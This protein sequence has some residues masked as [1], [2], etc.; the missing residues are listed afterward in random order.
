MRLGL[1]RQR[2]DESAGI[3]DGHT[4]G[5]ADTGADSDPD[6][7]DASPS[8]TMRRGD[9]DPSFGADGTSRASAPGRR[10]GVVDGALL[11]DGRIVLLLSVDAPEGVDANLIALARHRS[12]GSL[13]ESF[14]RGGFVEHVLC[15]ERSEACRDLQPRAL[16]ALPDGRLLIAA[17]DREN[18]K[19]GRLLV[20][21]TAGNLDATF[22]E[23]G[24]VTLPALVE[25]LALKADGGVVGVG[26]SADGFALLHLTADLMLD[27]EF[28]RDG[29]RL[30]DVAGRTALQVFQHVAVQADGN[31]VAAGLLSLPDPVPALAR[32]TPEGDPDVAF[33]RSGWLI[34]E[35]TPDLFGG[36]SPAAGPIALDGSGGLLVELPESVA[37]RRVRRLDGEGS[38][39]PSWAGP[40]GW[41]HSLFVAAD[42]S[43]VAA[44]ARVVIDFG[45]VIPINGELRR[46][47][48][49]GAADPEF[50]E[51]GVAPVPLVDGRPVFVGAAL[52]QPD[53]KII[54]A[55]SAPD[56]GWVL[57]ASSTERR[58]PR[59]QREPAG[60]RHATVGAGGDARARRRSPA[61]PGGRSFARRLAENYTLGLHAGARVLDQQTR[62]E[63]AF[64]P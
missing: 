47:D 9:L 62:K 46:H 48:R 28:G 10:A 55:S 53:G 6:A 44:A 25:D 14:G 21:T 57:F 34:A 49:D 50:G 45:F 15:S 54:V 11:A 51:A 4:G 19:E 7:V 8:P 26:G 38:V 31:V 16:L 35:P 52:Q 1:E 63:R 5:R 33:G 3:A 59:R 2:R 29:V 64:G 24:V 22:G 36:V 23:D 32:F 41:A 17:G 60:A 40:P 13:D 30:F 39:D 18:G 43:L 12:D 61:V 42:G 27:E 58:G 56:G 37:S 20:M